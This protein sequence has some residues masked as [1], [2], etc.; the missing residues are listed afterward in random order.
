[1]LIEGNVRES[2]L[3]YPA[4]ERIDV[5]RSFD[6]VRAALPLRSLPLVVLSADRLGGHKSHQ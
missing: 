6:Q 4:L 5:D 3:L 1:M 2:L